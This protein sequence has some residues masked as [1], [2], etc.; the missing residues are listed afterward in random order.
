MNREELIEAASR[1]E[2]PAYP[3]L[4]LVAVRGEGS[5][6][7]DLDGTAY[8]DLYGGHAVAAL[9][10]GHDKLASAIAEQSK[11]LL[12]QSNAVA[13]EVRAKAAEKLIEVAPDN[14]ARVFFVNSGAAPYFFLRIWTSLYAGYF[15]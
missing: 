4:D 14:M 12:F 7:Y 2:M 11:T 10:Y 3:R 9:G 15:S 13:L 6:L 8:L 5:R 1:Y